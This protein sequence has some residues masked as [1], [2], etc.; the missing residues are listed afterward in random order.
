M[1]LQ[2]AYLQPKIQREQ[3]PKLH[4][5][6]KVDKLKFLIKIAFSEEWDEIGGHFALRE[7]KKKKDVKKLESCL[8]SKFFDS[9]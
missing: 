9:F 5:C 6:S 7:K 4:I 3:K 8:N 1:V 2:F